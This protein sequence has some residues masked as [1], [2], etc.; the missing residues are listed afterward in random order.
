MSLEIRSLA[1]LYP[2]YIFFETDT[3]ERGA[4]AVGISITPPATTESGDREQSSRL[5]PYN[6]AKG[7]ISWEITEILVL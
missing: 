4:N 2:P 5:Q 6:A 1:A 7:L 3:I